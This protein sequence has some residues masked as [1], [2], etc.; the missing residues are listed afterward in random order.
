MS[1]LPGGMIRSNP[2]GS[3]VLG[4]PIPTTSPMPLLDTEDDTELRLNNFGFI[5][6]LLI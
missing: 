6:F 3:M 2:D 4:L 1:N 5:F